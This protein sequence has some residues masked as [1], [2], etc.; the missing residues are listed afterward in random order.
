MATRQ[1][2]FGADASIALVALAVA[3]FGW[4]AV[5]GPT[6]AHAGDADQFRS[7][8]WTLAT[9]A[10]GQLS[11]VTFELLV[12]DDGSG[13]FDAQASALHADLQARFPGAVAVEGGEVAAQYV[14]A[15]YS[16]HNNRA[17]WAYNPAGKPA[18]LIVDTAAISDAAASWGTLGANFSFA[19]DGLTTAAPNGCQ[20]VPDGHNTVGWAPIGHGVL[21]MTCTYWNARDGATE[22]DMQID[23]AWAWTTETSVIKVDLQSVVTHEFGHALGVDHPC[24]FT[25]PA[26]CTDSN[27]AAVMYGSYTMGTNKRVQQPDDLAAIM[28]VYG[29]NPVAPASP[30]S[31]REQHPSTPAPQQPLLGYRIAIAVLSRQ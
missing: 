22:F 2:L 9:E 24:D 5:T 16:W 26:T 31:T 29:A 1:R 28:A 17:N 14:L 10:N 27:R 8:D 6:P 23:P 15:H 30:S 4:L 20:N 21:A 11:F 19:S 3:A 12:K 25:R 13:D 18:G 7:A